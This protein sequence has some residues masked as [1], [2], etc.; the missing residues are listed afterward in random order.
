M[1]APDTVTEAT[2]LLEADGYDAT[3]TILD[4]GRL[5]FSGV[6]A[7]CELDEAVVERM[8]RFEGDSDPGDEMV[9]FGLLFPGRGVRGTLVSAFGLAADPDVLSHLT[10]IASRIDNP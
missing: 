2:R 8:Y 1:D 3:V 6:D 4:G 9:V 5:R 7:V 10:Y